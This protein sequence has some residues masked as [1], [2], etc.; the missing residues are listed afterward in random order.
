[1]ENNYLDNQDFS[2]EDP[3]KFKKIVELMVNISEFT[4]DEAAKALNEIISSKN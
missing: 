4:Y 3:E 2:K 1:M